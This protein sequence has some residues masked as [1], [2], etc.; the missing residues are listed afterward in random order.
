MKVRTLTAIIALIVFLP[1]LLK[2][3]LVLMIFA[4][5]LALIALKELLN[6][7]MIKF[8]SVPGLISA[9]GLIIIMLPQHA[10]PWV[11]V[12]QLKSLIAMSFIVLSYTVLSKN[13]FSFMDAAFCLM[14]VAYV[15]IGFMFFYETRSEDTGAYLFGKMMGKHKLWPVISPNKTIEGFIGGL[16]CSLIVPLAMLYFVDFNMNVWI[17]LGVTL[18]LSLF[19][20]LGDLV[21]SGFKRHFGVKDSGRI[22]PGHGGILDRFDSFMFV[23]PLLNILLIQS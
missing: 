14:S 21:E 1:I 9:V 17:L 2:G 3:G 20:Q 10:G 5:I 4:N 18:I 15:G 12:I 13:R 19:G 22:L 8:V 23:L 6:M 16:F 11:Q 7:N